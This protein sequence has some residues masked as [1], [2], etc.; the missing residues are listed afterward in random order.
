[1]DHQSISDIAETAGV[2]IGAVKSYL[3]RARDRLRECARARASW[4]WS[5]AMEDPDERLIIRRPARGVGAMAGAL[6]A[7]D[8]RRV[9]RGAGAVAQSTSPAS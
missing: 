8:R 1:M 9:D 6:L 2:F 7:G 4:D 5:D 3:S